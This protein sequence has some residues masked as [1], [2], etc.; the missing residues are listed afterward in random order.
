MS[1]KVTVTNRQRTLD[2]DVEF[3]EQMAA[4]LSAGVIR[5]LLAKPPVHLEAQVIEQIG[6]RGELSL[7]LVSNRQ[8]RKLNKEWMGKDRPTDVLSFPLELEP[9]MAEELPWEVGEI[10]I[11][12]EKAEEQ[13]DSYEHSFERELAFLFVHGML[14]VLGFDHM[15]PDGE[16]DMFSRQKS[17]LNKC[18]FKR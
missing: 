11:S 12:V 17:V 10:V 13:A 18:G 15:E 16:K 7:V 5:N 9:P 14:H 6:E 1:S 3:V 8:I 4:K 2:M